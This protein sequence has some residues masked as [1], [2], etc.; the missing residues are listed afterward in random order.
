MA[1]HAYPLILRD[2]YNGFRQILPDLPEDYEKWSY[3]V[4]RKKAKD[5][6]AYESGGG[7]FESHDVRVNG[8]KF[9]EYCQRI[10]SSPTISVLYNFVNESPL[11]HS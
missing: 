10:K 11:D 9:V 7:S 8:G 5:R 3:E 4:E 6:H 1:I 2:D